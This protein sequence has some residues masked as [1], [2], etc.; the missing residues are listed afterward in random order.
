MK[1]TEFTNFNLEN[2]LNFDIA[3]DL[4]IFMK[5]DPLFYRKQYFP[6]VDVIADKYKENNE[7]DYKTKIKPVIE[8]GLGIYIKKFNLD[9]R[10]KDIFSEQ[11][12]DK[13]IDKI[14]ADDIECRSNQNDF[15]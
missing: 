2:D 9:E 8:N 1:L 15:K 12:V 13:V 7:I 11:D 14:F 5:N 3:E 4:Y 6:V 10:L